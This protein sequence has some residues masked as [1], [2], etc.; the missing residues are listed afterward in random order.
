MHTRIKAVLVTI[1]VA[2]QASGTRAFTQSSLT[3]F[4]VIFIISGPCAPRHMSPSQ[5]T[6]HSHVPADTTTL[7]TVHTAPVLWMRSVHRLSPICLDLSLVVVSCFLLFLSLFS[8]KHLNLCESLRVCPLLIAHLLCARFAGSRYLILLCQPLL[9]LFLADLLL[10]CLSS[11]SLT[12]GCCHFSSAA[13]AAS[14][15][16]FCLQCCSQ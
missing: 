5:H 15:P 13:S 2:A 6:T 11:Y 10:S 1:A 7:P 3:L 14:V 8:P 4:A 9:F 16:P 12:S